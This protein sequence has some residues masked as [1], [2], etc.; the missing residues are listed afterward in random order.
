L[1][2]GP[3]FSC[4]LIGGDS[5]L[6]ECGEVLLARGHAV[7]A[8]VTAAP[9][10]RAWAGR[11][12]LP[13]LDAAGD[14]AAEL[15]DTPFDWL[16]SITHLALIPE[17][18]LALPARGAV[19]FHDGP[20]PHY[21][22]LNTPVWALIHGE[23]EHG[24]TWHRITGGVDEGDVLLQRRF[25]IQ[26]GET[27][28]SLN[29]R[30]FEAGLES[31][32]EL[33]DRL[34]AGDV[35]GA[36]QDL[37]LRRYFGRADRPAAAGVLDWTRPAA[38][39]DA[40][41]RA[42]DFGRYANPLT[43][44]KLCHE[45]T[46][47]TVVRAQPSEDD[48]PPGTLLDADERGL[49]IAA[50]TGALRCTEFRTLTGAELTPAA[51]QALLGI[52]VGE[53]LRG[54][55]EAAR[56]RLSALDARGAR[57]EGATARRLASLEPLALPWPAPTAPE[58][59]HST[60]PVAL[61]PE[62]AAADAATRVEAVI[63]AFGVVLA[64][65]CAR[66]ELT[67]G[68]RDDAL[69]AALRDVPP[70]FASRGLLTL[71]APAS[72]DFAAL[73]GAAAAALTR[74]REDGAC[75]LDLHA[76][77]PEL[78]GRTLPFAP[79]GLDAAVELRAQPGAWTPGTHDAL[80]LLLGADGAEVRLVYDRARIGAAAA[81]RLQSALTTLLAQLAARP[82]APLGELDLLPAAELR[83]I[84]E[85][86]N[87]TAQPGAGDA[88]V[89][90]AIEARMRRTPDAVALVGGERTMS[91]AE[92]DRQSAAL[93]ARLAALGAGPG[94]LVGVHL[95][96]TPELVVAVLGVLR[97]GAA[98]VPLDP[99]FPADRLD[100]M[101]A[102]AQLRLV[103]TQTALRARLRLPPGAVA[104]ELDAPDAAAAATAAPRR[105]TPQDLAYVIYTSGSTGR[106]KGV[107]VEHR[108]VVNFFAGMD[109]RIPHDPPGRWL[110]VT[111]LSF[112]ISV[113]ELLWTLARGFEVV[114]HR[115]PERKAAAPGAASTQRMDFGLF[116]WGNDA[117]PGARKY[118]LMLEAARFGDA[119]GFSSIWT[120]ERHFHAFGGP[121]PNPSVTGAAIA[122]VTTRIGIRAG[123]CVSPLHH[124]IRVAE[125]WAVVDNLSNGR[126][127]ISFASGWQPD[128][129]VLRPENFADHKGQ[130]L[131]D[132]ELVR[133]LWRGEAPEFPGPKGPVARAT[134]PRPVQAELPVWI[135]SA[136]NPETY[137]MA[138]SAGAN[139]LTHLLGQSVE[140]VAEKI[141]IYRKAR[142]E[143]GHDP[144]AG[145][146]TL[147]L[148]AYVG[149]DLAQIRATVREPMKRYLASATNLVKKYAWSFPAFKRPDA[150][151][152]ALDDLDLDGLAPEEWDAMMEHA[153]QRYFETSGLFGTP[154]S[155]QPMVER[156]KQIGV[157]EIGCLIDYGLPVADVLAALPALDRARRL[158]NPPAVAGATEV[159]LREQVR[160]RR[161]SHLQ[162]TPSMAR[163]LLLD[164][165]N[166]GAFA[167]L[168][169]L[170]I[171]GEAFP[172]ALARS[173]AAA[174]GARIQNMYGPTETT[175]WSATHEV[176][177][178]EESVPIGRPIANTQLYVLDAHRRPL[179][180]GV[181]GDL[182]IGGA[183][184]VRGYLGRP[185]LTA[186]RF[187][188]N[189]FRPGE[190]MYA[191]GDVA[192]WRDDGVLEFLGR[193]D[194]QVKIR[195]HRIELSEIEARLAAHPQVRE[196]V[197]VAGAD[198][199]GEPRLVGYVT[200]A[201]A[202][203]DPAALREHLRALLPES[204]VPSH[205]IVLDELPLTPN[206]KVDRQALPAPEQVRS[207][208]RPA[209]T[210]A[211]APAGAL[212]ERIAACWRQVL[213][214]E[215]VGAT[216]NFFDI[217]G[218]S[219][220]V[221]RLQ[222]M[223]KDSLERP[224][225]LTDLY[226][227]PTVRSLAEWLESDGEDAALAKSADRAQLRR[228]SLQRRRTRGPQA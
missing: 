101:L 177:P 83:T 41:V 172:P 34:A 111:S 78:H 43:T 198:P 122:A 15:A 138:G 42:L 27:A 228:A 203:P 68:F 46:A 150:P 199:A 8:V 44:A 99:A 10:V 100:F 151:A 91:Y 90:E 124:P 117:G 97:A 167:D 88:C 56:A 102:D 94:V 118:E 169:Q 7:R 149:D 113:L 107:M 171:G 92:L 109:A 112:D 182:F 11:K 35:R 5:L 14:Y 63:G 29:T 144:A 125:E 148:H 129:F 186:E 160:R 209:T 121:F 95:E 105:A 126:V 174:S 1:A 140:E 132:V 214:L 24:I 152:A 30:C 108:N 175:I 208:A 159:P 176:D 19:N 195:G 216:E 192:R 45:R 179:P 86:W 225:S 64:R 173:L 193:S 135:T 80:T 9:R 204:M 184:V 33:V 89:H 161:V 12:G 157:N 127:G 28:L 155:V 197:V 70:L 220:L 76:R 26:P 164:E 67:L 13:V 114:I 69:D 23:A 54:P 59:G 66:A 6:M 115:E 213:G 81:L 77:R 210:A 194:H 96:R 222:R 32:G 211:S 180:P 31:F 136:G 165:E 55:D 71:A 49:T 189:P 48:G 57:R 93:A 116:L 16:F 75:A 158:A 202:P 201:G 188:P 196:C 162:C 38:E 106:P 20:L 98:Y 50:G 22:G 142:A 131:R 53:R 153:F 103:I 47:L 143:A 130:M 187:V 119:H 217:G 18:A 25:P 128:D 40:L 206:A 134:L 219:L 181:P 166:R 223:L 141:L 185:E 65:L 145:V 39:L 4:A 58:H 87:A 110:A 205:V 170:M 133:R 207:A 227:F 61:P 226:R 36:P 79:G 224:L 51:A 72:A 178:R 21:A 82:A 147:M 85:E 212:Q 60:L 221:V 191:T 104:L 120:P 218:H 200:A 137:A 168:A 62:L 154:E 3:S 84:L 52:A 163:M 74:A 123:S 2:T 190:R 215:Q 37:R 139:V 73:R 17:R 183:G 146:V 156:L